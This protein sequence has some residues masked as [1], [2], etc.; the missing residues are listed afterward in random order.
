M[1]ERLAWTA[2]AGAVG[3][4]LG[5]IA[6]WFFGALT[7]RVYLEWASAASRSDST[8]GALGATEIERAAAYAGTTAVIGSIAV[9]L[10]TAVFMYWCKK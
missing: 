3:G 6:G 8:G 5:G 10:A 2:V 9:A 7:S 1:N 4:L